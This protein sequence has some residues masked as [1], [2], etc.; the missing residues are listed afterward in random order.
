MKCESDKSQEAR[1]L[2]KLV[3]AIQVAC[4]AP[5]WRE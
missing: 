1:I 5:I 4:P 2:K 3:V